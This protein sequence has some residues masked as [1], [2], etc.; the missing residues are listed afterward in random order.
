M[1][2]G[3]PTRRDA[4]SSCDSSASAKIPGGVF[5]ACHPP[6]AL[7][8]W[9]AAETDR[10]KGSSVTLDEIDK[11][12]ADWNTKLQLASDNLLALTQLITYE[13]LAGE[14]GWPK[15]Q[16][17]AASEARVGPALAAMR[18]LWSHY[19][20]LTDLVA[21]ATELRDALSW[22]LPSGKTLEEVQELLRGPSIKLPPSATPLQ[23]RGLLTAAEVAQSI[24]PQ[25]LL[26]A[27]T[28]CFDTARDAVLAVDAAWNRL[29]PLLDQYAA[30]AASLQ[31]LAADL[32]ADPAGAL[33]EVQGRIASLRSRVE[34]D[35]LDVT[36]ECEELARRLAEVRVALRQHAQERD[37]TQVE[38]ATARNLLCRL[39]E[40]HEQAKQ[41]WAERELK[42]QV[43]DAENLPK[44]LADE[45][46]AALAPWLAKL[47]STARQGSWKAAHV[48]LKKWMGIAGNYLAAEE[49]AR[50]ANREL[51]RVRRDLRG[52]LDALKAKARDCGRA[53]DAELAALA[54]EAGQL[55]QSRPT[56][57]AR[58]QQLVTEYEACLL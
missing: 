16:L 21:R 4:T 47:E 2:G 19:S 43:D 58:A 53:E 45:A 7:Y 22:L 49:A 27:M 41:A 25:R 35:P 9:P 30:E 12:L 6:Y 23:Q 11:E 44:P 40:A 32:G 33:A 38:L 29:L 51:L 36:T 28:T 10:A 52:L 56:P 39:E 5:A 37:Q 34:H 15:V 57:L 13:R 46:V 48:G 42:V 50:E 20:L 55:L 17:T 18:E 14:G 3:C 1:T 8:V 24:T 54:Q 26:E 31:Q